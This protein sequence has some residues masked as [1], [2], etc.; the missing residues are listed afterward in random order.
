MVVVV[1]VVVV[2][3]CH[4]SP[5]I[6]VPQSIIPHCWLIAPMI[7]PA[8]SGLQSWGWVLGKDLCYWLVMCKALKPRL[9]SPR[10]LTQA[11][12]WSGLGRAQGSAHYFWSLSQAQKPR[13]CGCNSGTT[14][15]HHDAPSPPSPPLIYWKLLL[16]NSK[17]LL[18]AW[19]T[20]AAQIKGWGGTVV[21]SH[22]L[23][24]EVVDVFM[25]T[26][27]SNKQCKV[28][29]GQEVVC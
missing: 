7:H 4:F 20:G 26:G 16:H 1:V 13:L 15:K 5:H 6:P 10:S 17:L 2:I 11:E 27:I 14:L 3:H 23:G 28:K 24:I 29:L 21:G 8:S 18:T 12:P 19:L 22:S 9:P 25:A